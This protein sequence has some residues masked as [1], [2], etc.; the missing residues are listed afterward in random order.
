M[1]YKFLEL[2]QRLWWMWPCGK[3]TYYASATHSQ[4]LENVTHV[5]FWQ[6][7]KHTWT[8]ILDLVAS[9]VGLMA[10]ISL[11]PTL[12]ENATCS[13][14]STHVSEGL[15]CSVST[16]STWLLAPPEAKACWLMVVST[17]KPPWFEGPRMLPSALSS[18]SSSTESSALVSPLAEGS[19][20]ALEASTLPKQ[21]CL[22]PTAMWSRHRPSAKC[23]N[24]PRDSLGPL[25]SKLPLL[26]QSFC[27]GCRTSCAEGLKSL[28]RRRS[29]SLSVLISL[30]SLI[31]CLD[32]LPL[33]SSSCSLSV[34]SSSSQPDG[35]PRAAARSSTGRDQKCPLGE[36]T[37]C[38]QLVIHWSGQSCWAPVR[39]AQTAGAPF[40][41]KSD[42]VK[43]LEFSCWAKNNDQRYT[44]NHAVDTGTRIH[45][46][47]RLWQTT[48][49]ALQ[50]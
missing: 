5:S 12:L 3:W 15:T 49:L 17:C 14:S 9:S 31:F 48:C 24:S 11:C 2:G 37:W 27:S 10:G 42:L 22:L 29:C 23:T 13:G 32:A 8:S 25:S 45:G 36:C 26:C 35:L 33:C 46:V 30:E 1:S 47:A 39:L 21:S 50:Q 34:L 41:M 20:A 7:S 19:D 18:R 16:P 40:A 28:R 6:A 44:R 4:A 43:C 38:S